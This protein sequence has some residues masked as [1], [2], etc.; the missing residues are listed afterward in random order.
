MQD[1]LSQLGVARHGRYCGPQGG[2]ESYV[3]PELLLDDKECTTM[4]DMWSLG[5]TYLEMFTNS[6]P[7]K[8]NSR[9][10]LLGMLNKQEPP[11][12]LGE[13]QPCHDDVVKPL[14]EY[15]P[16]SRKTASDLV[17]LL[18]SRLNLTS[19]YGFEW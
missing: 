9:R 2:T 5:V 11:H 16:Q 12:A 6:V 3:A 18:K 15:D 13:L 19:K 7:W 10:G 1:S 8:C 4:S 17:Q 14:I